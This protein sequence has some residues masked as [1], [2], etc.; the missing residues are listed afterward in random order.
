MEPIEPVA[1]DI[2]NQTT[3]DV[4]PRRFTYPVSWNLPLGEPGSEGLKLA[5]YSVLRQLGDVYSVARAAIQVRKQEIEGLE[6]DIVA[7]DEAEKAMQGNPLANEDF[8]TR[9]QKAINFFLHPDPDNYSDYQTWAGA[10]MEEIL[11]ID[12]LS[13]AI[14]PTTKPGKGPFGSSVGGLALI[15]G[16]T[17]RPQL[18][19]RGARPRP[20]N[21][22]YQQYLWGV[23]RVD[24]MDIILGTDLEDMDAP[25]QEYTARQMIYVPYVRRTWTPY[26]FC[27]SSDTEVLTDQ[28]WKLF[29][30]LDGTEKM[31]TRSAEGI[32][33]WQ[34]PTQYIRKPHH[35]TMYTLQSQVYD[36]LLT[37][38]HRL[39]VQPRSKSD[40]VGKEPSLVPVE[41]FADKPGRCSNWVVPGTS[42]WFAPEPS[43]V[44]IPG[45]TRAA[46]T[47]HPRPDLVLKPEVAAALVGWFV[48]EGSLGQGYN[49]ATGTGGYEVV[50]SQYPTSTKLDRLIEVLDNTGLDWS[51]TEK[52]FIINH[53][54]LWTWLKDQCYVPGTDRGCFRKRIPPFMMNWPS[55]LL[56]VLWNALMDGDG[57]VEANGFQ[58]YVT[59]S[60]MLT[61]QLL[62]LAQK[63]G[64]EAWYHEFQSAWATRTQ[65]R[66]CLRTNKCTPYHK[67]PVPK[68]VQ[69]DGE[70]FCVS[71]PNE[72]LYV[73]RNGRTAW[74]GNS[75]VERS[76]IPLGTGLNRQNWALQFFAEGTIPGMFIT[77]GPDIQS[78]QQIRI[79][80]STL[81]ALAGDT[82]WKHRIIVLP[83]GSSTQPFKQFTFA[84]GSDDIIY[85]QVL[86]AFDVMPQELGLTPQ[87]GGGLIGGQATVAHQAQQINQ[88][89]ALR[90]LLQFLKRSL[91]DFVLQK[92]FKQ[93]DME[94]SWIGLDQ[95]EDADAVNNRLIKS[96][97]SALLSVDEARKQ[98]GMPPWGLL[99]TSMPLFVT[100]TGPVPA[101]GK[102]VP[103]EVSSLPDAVQIMLE[104]MQASQDETDPN[105][106]PGA[107]GSPEAQGSAPQNAPASPPHSPMSPTPSAPAPSV[108]PMTHEPMTSPLHQGA[109][110][111]LSVGHQ[112]MVL[113]EIEKVRRYL[114]KGNDLSNWKP[115]DI[116]EPIWSIMK[117]NDDDPVG[118]GRSVIRAMNTKQRRDATLAALVASAAGALGALAKRLK[119]HEISAAQFIDD[120]AKVLNDSYLSVY[121]ESS[122]HAMEDHNVAADPSDLEFDK[123]ALQRSG[124]ES[125]GPEDQGQR[126][127]LFRLARALQEKANAE[128]LSQRID[129]YAATMTNAYEEGYGRTVLLGHSINPTPTQVDDAQSLPT[130]ETSALAN[131]EAAGSSYVVP[132]S[133]VSGDIDADF[134]PSTNADEVDTD[135]PTQTL[136]SWL[137]PHID[138]AEEGAAAAD[139]VAAERKDNLVQHEYH[140][141]WV[142]E[143]DDNTCDLCAARN[144]KKYTI[145]DLPG[146]PGS[147]NFGGPICMG[148]QLCRCHLDYMQSGKLIARSTNPHRKHMLDDIA[149][150]KFRVR[151]ARMQ[152]EAEERMTFLDQL[153]DTISDQEQHDAQ[154]ELRPP[155]ST[156]AR[157]QMRELI[158]HELADAKTR[159]NLY[160]GV[161]PA[162]VEPQDIPASEVKAEFLRRTREIYR[163][164]NLQKDFS[165]PTPIRHG[166][167][168][169]DATHSCPE[170]GR[171]VDD[172]GHCEPCDLYV[173]PIA[174]EPISGMVTHDPDT[175][176]GSIGEQVYGMLSQVYPASVLHW[177]R[178]ASWTYRPQVS[179]SSI[180]M[181]RRPG[182]RDQ[183]KVDAMTQALKDGKRFD[184]VILVK[185]SE[186]LKIADGYHRTLAYRHAKRTYIPAYV[187]QDA[188]DHGPW[189]K[190]MHDRKLNKAY[191]SFDAALLPQLHIGA[192][193]RDDE[194]VVL[195]T[196]APKSGV[197]ATIILDKAHSQDLILEPGAT[198]KVLSIS[199]DEVVMEYV[200]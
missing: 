3:G 81:N 89:K 43:P 17:I 84:D 46:G 94:W 170:C 200:P 41:F 8:M 161:T 183:R 34:A 31:A 59:S 102:L 1:I 193:L 73:R 111:A 45:T 51:H 92:I 125:V 184:P 121:G 11:V 180:R 47:H 39:L 13:I 22:C 169:D 199:Q 101:A 151:P 60:K 140:I 136:L 110:G 44:V 49:A 100:P 192:M 63:M 114:K 5:P 90:P 54:P 163:N 69:Y 153:P 132:Q 173:L 174:V 95:G 25:I 147:G 71:V 152:R 97:A 128:D 107:P 61:D 85:Q 75:P 142:T 195:D 12:A 74:C 70:V 178:S 131:G 50:I 37:P 7:T 137:I 146:Y 42:T 24:L 68:A 27:Y 2:P 72:V 156:R 83:A 167:A 53:K 115:F 148:G 10:L 149:A 122:R 26:G 32:F 154:R 179:L 15:D 129:Q 164:A 86:M 141:L 67:V 18:D 77:P 91:F 112:K 38:E 177:V 126:S 19:V 9:R 172:E 98:M 127:W 182:G 157:A 197:I 109:S 28:G 113:A 168:V 138:V 196:V 130:P 66:V 79:L 48:S 191:R 23:P 14:Q 144:G 76:L 40:R 57:H 103:G 159:Q 158:R 135:Q 21:P 123:L 16:T 6:W 80:Q 4:E 166:A 65:Y 198:F 190:E 105:A 185:T 36:L 20:P 145:H 176:K 186:G 189:D 58:R 106:P 93:T 29:P 35:G 119:A 124:L 108:H 30:D 104:N 171:P 194:P 64:G 117:A 139:A 162:T 88:R 160:N 134:A 118:A 55:D 120:G 96:V 82:A 143:M 78:P 188:G 133:N 187:A 155:M 52:E 175:T 33:E 165:S 116:P 87:S 150:G 62:E 181:E 56:Q 99:E